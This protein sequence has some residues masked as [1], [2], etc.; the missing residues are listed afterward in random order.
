MY[1]CG[2]KLHEN[3]CMYGCMFVHMYVCMYVASVICMNVCVCMHAFFWYVHL[4]VP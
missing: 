3:I 4:S 1:V 2:C